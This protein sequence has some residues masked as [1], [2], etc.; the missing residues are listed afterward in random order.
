MATATP[1]QPLTDDEARLATLQIIGSD[2]TDIWTG[3]W[4]EAL[5]TAA[6]IWSGEPVWTC[7]ICNTPNSYW[8]DTCG[9]CAIYRAA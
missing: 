4:H 5:R 1:G 9:H 6:A 7:R 8:T 3:D 2:I